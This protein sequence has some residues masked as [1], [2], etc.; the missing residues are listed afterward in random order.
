MKIQPK[1]VYVITKTIESLLMSKGLD[2]SFDD[3]VMMA[4]SVFTQAIINSKQ[5]LKAYLM[6]DFSSL[7]FD[8]V[9]QSGS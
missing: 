5:A 8:S 2:E 6:N 7:V 3:S 1:P 4:D 9:V